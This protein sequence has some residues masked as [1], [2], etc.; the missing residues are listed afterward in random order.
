M[1]GILLDRETRTSTT[2]LKRKWS[3]I[4][5]V[6]DY[7][8][9]GG[10]N[11]RSVIDLN[12]ESYWV[13]PYTTRTIPSPWCV[14]NVLTRSYTVVLSPLMDPN[15]TPT[16]QFSPV[17]YSD[18]LILKRPN[19]Y[20]SSVT[21]IM[22]P[23]LGSLPYLGDDSTFNPRTFSTAGFR[24]LHLFELNGSVSSLFYLFDS[25]H[26]NDL[27]DY[28]HLISFLTWLRNPDT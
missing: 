22:W 4:E 18:V 17:F 25:F 8:C 12:L 10:R 13:D 27:M 1:E 15:L 3:V 24:S 6:R 28:G 16:G 5:G 21:Q 7:P 2:S 23:Y 19:R 26:P 11:R 20:E 14:D 9:W